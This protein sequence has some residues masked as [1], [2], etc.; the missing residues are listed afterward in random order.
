M[1]DVSG[2]IIRNNLMYTEPQWQGGTEN[3]IDLKVR[4]ATPSILIYGNT[5]YGFQP[6]NT[7]AG[8]CI[9]IHVN[10][11]NVNIHDNNITNCYHALAVKPYAPN[12]V[13]G[14][15]SFLDRNVYY[16]GTHIN[17]AG[18]NVTQYID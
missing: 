7:S 8:D 3:A 4:V 1:Q 16:N 5:M 6:S 14:Y 13:S 17:M 9:V 18:Q 2:L 12:G 10:C 15:E 11:T